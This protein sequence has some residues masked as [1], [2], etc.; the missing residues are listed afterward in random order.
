MIAS[1]HNKSECLKIRAT[2]DSVDWDI[3]N[4]VGWTAAM[5]AVDNFDIKIL[6]NLLTIP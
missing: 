4:N 6:R 2:Q 1:L 5:H 3:Q